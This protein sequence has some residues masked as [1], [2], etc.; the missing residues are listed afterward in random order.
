MLYFKPDFSI[1]PDS[2]FARDTENKLVRRNFWLDLSDASLVM[3]FNY[4]IGM[5]LTKEE[6]KNHLI[7]IKRDNLIDRVCIQEILPPED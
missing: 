5:S 7:D 6:K 3:L 2:P 1:H 4:G